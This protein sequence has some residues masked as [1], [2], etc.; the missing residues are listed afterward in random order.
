MSLDR[1][2]IRAKLSPDMHAALTVLAEVDRLDLGEWIERELCRVIV[3]RVHAATVIAT[4]CAAKGI[5]GNRREEPGAR[6]TTRD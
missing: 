5:A 2:D 1:K 4:A 3:D 6:G